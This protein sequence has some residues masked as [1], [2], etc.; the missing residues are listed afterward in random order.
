MIAVELLLRAAVNTINLFYS[1]GVVAS[2]WCRRWWHMLLYL[3]LTGFTMARWLDLNYGASGLLGPTALFQL[4]WAPA[5][6]LGLARGGIWASR[7]WPGRRDGLL[8][9]ALVAVFGVWAVF[10]FGPARHAIAQCAHAAR[11]PLLDL[12]VVGLSYLVLKLGHVLV[13]ERRRAAREVR[14]LDLAAMAF[15]PPTYTLGPMHR[16]EEFSRSFAALPGWRERHWD[17]VVRKVV[18]GTF[19]CSV[20][21]PWLAAYCTPVLASPEAYGA[22]A[23]W[24]AMYAYALRIYLDFAGLS[25]IAIGF[26]AAMGIAVPENFARPYL[27]LDIQQFW[28]SW[29][30]TLTRWL[31]AYVFLPLS[32]RLMKTRLRRR[33]HTIAWLGYLVTFAFC[34]LW[35]GEGANYLVW[36]VWHGVG[37]GLYTALPARWKAPTGE[38]ARRLSVR[39]ALWWFATFHFVGVGWILFA[40]PLATAC[41]ALARM[42]GLG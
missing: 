32:K 14:Y 7:R 41:V 12:P 25:D 27:K 8:I 29:H 38:A 2:L 6:M 34:G 5:L 19:Q 39:G 30:M 17:T 4:A 26:G 20:L 3:V 35:H 24:L 36:G 11:L 40:C 23:L 9:A 16:L 22:G 31:Q 13:D 15:F 21:A 28:Q 10:K 37:L 33:P 1:A 42:V 18:W